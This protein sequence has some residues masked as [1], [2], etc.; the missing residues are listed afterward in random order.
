M[1]YRRQDDE[2]IIYP[3]SPCGKWDEPDYQPG[4]DENGS[5]IPVADGVIHRHALI[6][7][8]AVGTTLPELVARASRGDLNA[9]PLY[10]ES[11]LD[12][13]T[14]VTSQ[15]ASLMEAQNRIIQ[16]KNI[17][18]KLPAD[19]KQFYNQD[20]SQFLSALASGDYASRFISPKKKQAAADKAAREAIAAQ[21]EEKKFASLIARIKE[22][23]A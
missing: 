16:A 15:P 13:L 1:K 22:E 7:S 14:D 10:D 6:Q 12:A 20:P 3:A 21:E 4:V 5:E 18:A 11:K 8:A 9:V 19:Q 2:L 17:F 23:L